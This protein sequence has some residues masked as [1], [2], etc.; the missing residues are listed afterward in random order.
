MKKLFGGSESQQ[1]SGGVIDEEI[2][3]GFQIKTLE[4]KDGGQYRVCAEIS[5]TIGDEVKTHKLIRADMCASPQEASQI[6]MR[7]AKVVINEQG[8]RMFDT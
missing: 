8:D 1:T 2:Y 3:E 7:K 5:K 4:M 6:S